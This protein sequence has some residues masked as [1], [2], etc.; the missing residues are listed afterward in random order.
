MIKMSNDFTSHDCIYKCFFFV[1]H[2][3]R[4]MLHIFVLGCR[5]RVQTRENKKIMNRLSGLI[6]FVM[7]IDYVMLYHVYFIMR[8]NL[9]MLHIISA[10]LESENANEK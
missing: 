8:I 3:N 10:K 4:V 7:D 1:M 2:I 9:V 5:V 6:S